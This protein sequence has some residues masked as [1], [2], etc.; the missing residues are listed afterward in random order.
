ME[1]SVCEIEK[2]DGDFGRVGGDLGV[3]EE[4]VKETGVT[5]LEGW[6]SGDLVCCCWV[7]G[8]WGVTV[9]GYWEGIIGCGGGIFKHGVHLCMH[10]VS[11]EG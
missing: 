6:I 7:V 8:C 9:G 11:H 1:V 2:L 10:L 3:C 5:R 4:E